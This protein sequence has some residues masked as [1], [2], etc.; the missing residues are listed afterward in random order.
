[1]KF[2][3]TKGNFFF[4]LF[5]LLLDAGSRTEKKSG[6]GIQDKYPGS[7]TLP[8]QIASPM[9]DCPE[10]KS[11]QGTPKGTPLAMKIK[12]IEKSKR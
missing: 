7:A 6:A 8:K 9:Y 3:A 10:I 11:G 2:I 4:L 12:E 5:L 1:M